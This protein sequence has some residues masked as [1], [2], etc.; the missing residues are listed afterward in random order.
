M[1]NQVEI[2]LSVSFTDLKENI[3]AVL[4]D[5]ACNMNRWYQGVVTRL[6]YTLTNTLV[7]VWCGAHQLDL[8][9]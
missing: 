1:L 9:M 7:R 8:V 2:S 5:G 4:T 3:I 6:K